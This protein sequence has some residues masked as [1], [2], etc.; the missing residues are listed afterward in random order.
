MIMRSYL[1]IRLKSKLKLNLDNLKARVAKKEWTVDSF[2]FYTSSV[3]PR[4]RNP[5][6]CV[7]DYLAVLTAQANAHAEEFFVR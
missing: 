2:S 4:V 7:Y 5:T 1:C 3:G 6:R